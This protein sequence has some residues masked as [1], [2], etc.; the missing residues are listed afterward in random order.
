MSGGARKQLGS[1]ASSAAA[2]VEGV[3]VGDRRSY[4]GTAKDASHAAFYAGVAKGFASGMEGFILFLSRAELRQRLNDSLSSTMNA[5]ILYAALAAAV[6][7]FIRD[8]A[9]DVASLV[10]ALSRWGRILTLIVTLFLERK[11]KAT[12]AM[13]FDALAAKDPAFASAVRARAPAKRGRR[14]RLAKYKR[15]AKMTAVRL[16]GAFVARWLPGGRFVAIPALRYITLRPTLGGPA[17][18]AVSSIH[19]LPESVLALGHLD[20]LLVS[21]SEAVL[22]A[23]ELGFDAVRTYTKRLEWPDTQDYFRERYRGYVTG[24]GGASLGSLRRRLSRHVRKR[25]AAD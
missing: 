13:F 16:A 8:P 1:A 14:E 23:D 18:L 6:V 21:M 3:A 17:A 2:S 25:P 15:V 10:W 24:L 20:D 19:A 22:D 7:I 5:Q 9:D 11:V 12:E 4:T